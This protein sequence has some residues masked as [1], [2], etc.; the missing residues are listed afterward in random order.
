MNKYTENKIADIY[1]TPFNNEKSSGRINLEAEENGTP[2]FIQDKIKNNEKTNYAN[3]TQNIM[4]KTTLSNAFFSIENIDIIQNTLRSK[5]YAM[6]ERKYK[7][8]HQDGDQLK[9]IM[10]SIYLQNALNLKKNIAHQ[11]NILNIK[12]LDYAIPQVYGELISYIK[13]KEDISTLPKPM[14]RPV[15]PFIDKTMELKNFF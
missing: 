14:D 1:Q 3:S 6:T 9:I 4:E 11:V 12:V 5:I 15:L 13:Y 10:R 8:D 2:F 7:I